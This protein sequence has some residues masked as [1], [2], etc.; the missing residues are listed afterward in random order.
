MKWDFF[1]PPK[2][3][4]SDVT[5]TPNEYFNVQHMVVYTSTMVDDGGLL[6]A[7]INAPLC[8]LLELDIVDD[9]LPIPDPF[10]VE[11]V[12]AVPYGITIGKNMAIAV[13]EMPGTVHGVTLTG[14]LYSL[15]G[16]ALSPIFMAAADSAVL[17]WGGRRWGVA[18]ADGF[19]QMPSRIFIDNTL[20]AETPVADIAGDADNFSAYREIG[21]P[22]GAYGVHLV[23]GTT[24]HI[25]TVD[26]YCE[27]GDT[28][29][30]TSDFQVRDLL[31]NDLGTSIVLSG[32]GNQG[33]LVVM[34]SL[35]AFYLLPGT[36]YPAYYTPPV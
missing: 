3:G 6:T 23:G 34:Y 36:T 30:L 17:T 13:V 21:A 15:N 11:V 8:D 5:P 10:Y 2:A 1:Q 28:F 16:V 12:V 18:M 25:A 31:G 9:G 26:W 24:G 32:A 33:T 27:P 14:E 7:H 20:T 29:T 19:A 4:G 35:D 22:T